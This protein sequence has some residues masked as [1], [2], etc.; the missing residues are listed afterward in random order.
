MKL[1]TTTIVGMAVAVIIALFVIAFLSDWNFVKKTSSFMEMFFDFGNKT[2][3]SEV[4]KEE[5]V[6]SLNEYW[7]KCTPK[8][9]TTLK[10][11]VVGEGK[12]TKEYIFSVLKNLSWCDVL[13]SKQFGCG[14]RE[15]LI[16]GDIALPQII[17]A[18]CENNTLRV[19]S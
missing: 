17:V 9:N 7:S 13:Q 1:V 4:T 2:R 18:K 12:L 10:R 15:D 5:F 11:Y 8:M 6:A 16:V 19:Y 3:I 14:I